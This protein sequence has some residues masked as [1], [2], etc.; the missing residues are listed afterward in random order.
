MNKNTPSTTESFENS[1][2]KKKK[3]FVLIQHLF[4]SLCAVLWAWYELSCSSMT[5]SAR[6]TKPAALL[7]AQGAARE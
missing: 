1:F 4:P 6:E 7:T 3:S 5:R 2:Q